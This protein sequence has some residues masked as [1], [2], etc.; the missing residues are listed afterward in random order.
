MTELLWILLYV[1][2]FYFM[3]RY[4]GCG[5]HASH[6]RHRRP[7]LGGDASSHDGHHSSGGTVLSASR[8]PVCGMAVSE[9]SLSRVYRGR[10][11]R[12]CSKTCMDRFDNNAD[13]YADEE[14]RAS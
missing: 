5:G 11:Y 1:G 10:E 12:F 3:F 4:G 14:R 8:D 9:G 2:L 7:E 6:R 13:Q